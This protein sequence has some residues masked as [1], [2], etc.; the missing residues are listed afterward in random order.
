VHATPHFW[1]VVAANASWL[2]M[3]FATIWRLRHDHP[4]TRPVAAPAPSAV[5]A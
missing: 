3:P 5:P 1:I 2:L 4:F